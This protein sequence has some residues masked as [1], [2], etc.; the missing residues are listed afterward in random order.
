MNDEVRKPR[1]FVLRDETETDRR[2][3][4]K[5][6]SKTHEKRV[7]KEFGGK[8]QPFSGAAEGAKGDIKTEQVL[9]DHKFTDKLSYTITQ[10]I[11]VKLSKEAQEEGKDVP[12]LVIKFDKPVQELKWLNQTEWALIPSSVLKDLLASK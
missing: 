1:S 4:R 5:K 10:E 7:A 9:M 8:R 11:L 6:R 2:I 12:A 3:E